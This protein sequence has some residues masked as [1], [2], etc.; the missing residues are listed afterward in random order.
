LR[1]GEQ[2]Q[3]DLKT[4]F[5]RFMENPIYAGIN[6]EK[7][8]NGLPVIKQNLMVIVTVEQFNRANKGKVKVGRTKR[9]TENR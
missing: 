1:K 7:W 4:G 3:L 5:L 8:T 2:L 9:G 6:I